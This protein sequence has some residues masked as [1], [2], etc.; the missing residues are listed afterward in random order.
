[1]K[2]KTLL[3]PEPNTFLGWT[4]STTKPVDNFD[5]TKYADVLDVNGMKLYVYDPEDTFMGIIA[6]GTTAEKMI[7]RCKRYI[8]KKELSKLFSNLFKKK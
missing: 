8:L 7:K 5:V 6:D 1:M 3:K 2:L 4:Y